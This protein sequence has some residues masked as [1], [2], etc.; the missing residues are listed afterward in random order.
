MLWLYLATSPHPL[1]RIAGEMFYIH[2]HCALYLPGRFYPRT[3]WVE[4][5]DAAFCR[6]GVCL[7]AGCRVFEVRVIR[8][9]HTIPY[10]ITHHLLFQHAGISTVDELIRGS[11]GNKTSWNGSLETR[12]AHHISSSDIRFM[13]SL[14]KSALLLESRCSMQVVPVVCKQ[15]CV[16]PWEVH[17]KKYI[18]CVK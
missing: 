3:F 4:W 17:I 6:V 5:T 15:G 10:S 1:L 12:V 11:K 7:Y 16:I 18:F 2:P 14:F 9:L 13:L 8:L